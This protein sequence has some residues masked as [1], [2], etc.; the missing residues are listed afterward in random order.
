VKID[1]DTEQ[2]T[3]QKPTEICKKS[4]CAGARKNVQAEAVDRTMFFG[5]AAE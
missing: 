1:R 3:D 4:G 2:A 5:S